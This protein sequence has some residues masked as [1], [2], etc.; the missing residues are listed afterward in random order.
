[1]KSIQFTCQMLPQRV[2]SFCKLAMGSKIFFIFCIDSSPIRISQE[3]F[4]ILSN[5]CLQYQEYIV[6]WQKYDFDFR[7]ILIPLWLPGQTIVFNCLVLMAEKLESRNETSNPCS[8]GPP[9]QVRPA[10]PPY[11]TYIIL[12]TART[13]VHVW[14]Q[15]RANN[16]NSSK[17]N[18][19]FYR[20]EIDLQYQQ[21]ESVCLHYFF[22]GVERRQQQLGRMADFPPPVTFSVFDL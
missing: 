17:T 19:M 18:K 11:L 12:I 6:K 5:T 21:N 4:L 22:G 2:C 14:H 10:R 9:L 1:M 3:I 16:K 20:F 15:Y 13:P 8:A 7:K